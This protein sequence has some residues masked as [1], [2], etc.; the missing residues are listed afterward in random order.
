M[1][2]L[3]VNV[4]PYIRR[5]KKFNPVSRV[6]SVTDRRQIDDRIAVIYGE[7]NIVAFF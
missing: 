3:L 2:I 6:M 7:W 1:A 4:E 5:C